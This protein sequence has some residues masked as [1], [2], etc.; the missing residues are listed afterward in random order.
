MFEMM[1][2]MPDIWDI[3]IADY[4]LE[5][6]VSRFV[7]EAAL[8]PYMEFI[9]ATT[10]KPVVTVGRFTSPD[11]MA[12]QIKRGVMDFVGAARPSIADPFLPAKIETGDLGAIRECIGCNIC[13]AGDSTGTPIRCTQNP[14]MGE[15]WRK[16]WHPE[17]IEPAPAEESVLIVGAG[18]A[19]LEAARAL[20]K[21]GYKVMLA[22]A[23][24]ELGGR[25]TREAT[26]PGMSEYI[27]VRDYR[28]QQ[29]QEMVNVDIF[30]DSQMGVD[31]VME[32]GAD[33][34]CIATGA[35]WRRDRYDGQTYTRVAAEGSDPVLLTPDDIMNGI[36]PDG[37]VLVYDEDSYYMGGVIAE[38]LRNNGNEVTLAT[39]A[40]T[41]SAW[42]GMT[43]ER[44]RVRKHLAK[45][46]VKF[47]TAHELL[48][49][50]GA[51][52]TLGDIFSGAETP[53]PVAAVVMVTQRAPRDDLYQAL[54]A[55][56]DDN[57]DKLPFT[58]KR[59]G[60]CEAPAI[61]AAAT[62]AGHRYAREID[63]PPDPDEPLKHD[64]VDVG[65]T[66]DGAHLTR[67]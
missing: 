66:P 30:L 32:V 54:L 5:M 34:V 64:R 46:G 40:E 31:E 33:H 2:N 13:Y 19:G 12:S 3:N 23:T 26:L 60:D 47:Q 58:L 7:K 67:G 53:V 22:E 9:K 59:I 11:T 50:D 20:G 48:T 29:L 44:W 56:I 65:Q 24:T 15:E 37:P 42:A 36:L 39:T 62:Y 6:G 10:D 17:N 38:R 57:T 52:A 1:A 14:T 28:V 21:R 43:S 25:V 35:A 61:V 51:T 8:E 55:S 4:S 63:N 18:P 49:F 41:V 16:G 27:R 45:L